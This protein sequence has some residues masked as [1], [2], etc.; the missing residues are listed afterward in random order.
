M[1]ISKLMLIKLIVEK[2][3]EI[4]FVFI[5]IGFKGLDNLVVL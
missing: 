3:L 2:Y 4:I 5:N 1:Y